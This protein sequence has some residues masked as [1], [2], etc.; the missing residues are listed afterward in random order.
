MNKP[1]CA[2][3]GDTGYLPGKSGETYHCQWCALPAAG[4]IFEITASNVT[5]VAPSMHGAVL[6]A[7]LAE[8][9]KQDAQWGGASHDDEVNCPSDWLT[10]IDRQIEKAIRE[11][12]PLMI[13]SK[14]YTDAVR[15]RLV[16]IAALAVAGIESMDR[17]A[18]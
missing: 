4:N 7:I 16:K 6:D 8:R 15:A 5:L 14:P 13:D 11:T 12:A 18:K 9:G 1:I 3:C 2:H 17:K 10:Y